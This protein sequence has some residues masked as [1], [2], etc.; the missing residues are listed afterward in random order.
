MVGIT[1][2]QQRLNRLH[3]EDIRSLSEVRDR[4]L[5]IDKA[6]HTFA[7]HLIRRDD[8]RWSTSGCWELREKK[9]P[10]GRPLL[11]WQNSLARRNNICDSDSIKKL[12][13][14]HEQSQLIAG[15]Q[16]IQVSNVYMYV[17][18]YIY[19]CINVCICIYVC[20]C[21]YMYICM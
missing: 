5:H 4:I 15:R 6:K 7:G 16:V 12:G 1:L 18:V 17:Y 20:L 14:A 13:P 2:H 9:R 3:N 19:I 8:G 11:R 21:M 10:C